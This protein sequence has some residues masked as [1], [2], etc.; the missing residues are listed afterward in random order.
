MRVIQ[1]RGRCF[2]KHGKS[3]PDRKINGTLISYI[4]KKK[5]R[6]LEFLPVILKGIKG[7]ATLT[8]GIGKSGVCGVIGK[9]PLLLYNLLQALFRKYRCDAHLG[10]AATRF[11]PGFLSFV[12]ERFRFNNPGKLTQL[13]LH[14]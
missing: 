5:Q 6:R 10:R 7:Q 4:L 8:G 9:I 1:A 12:L 14:L 11:L 2:I 13:F 3:L